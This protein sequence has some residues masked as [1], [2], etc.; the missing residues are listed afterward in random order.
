MRRNTLTSCMNLVM[1]EIENRIG[2]TERLAA[3]F[4]DPRLSDHVRHG[5]PEMI[6]FRM[7]MIAA[8]YEDASNCDALR[9][10]PASNT[11]FTLK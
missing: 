2:I 5:L 4:D 1:T 11:V 10:E 8:G 9:A 3:C 6:R 7:L